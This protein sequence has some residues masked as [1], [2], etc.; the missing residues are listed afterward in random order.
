[1]GP[2]APATVDGASMTDLRLLAGLRG[3]TAAQS[4]NT[5]SSWSTT[6]ARPT[7]RS[8]RSRVFTDEKVDQVSDI[9]GWR[10]CDGDRPF[11]RGDDGL[12]SRRQT[13]AHHPAS[14]IAGQH[15]ASD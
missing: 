13:E 5:T 2:P 9:E 3:A 11:Q 15:E 1:M 6:D 10:R 7:T 4:G 14:P 8:P 12:R